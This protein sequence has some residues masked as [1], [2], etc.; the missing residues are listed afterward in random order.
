MDWLEQVIQDAM[1]KGEFDNLAGKGKPLNLERNAH[2]DP[3]KY[4]ANKMLKDGG[5]VWPWIEERNEIERDIETAQKTLARSY[6]AHRAAGSAPYARSDW[7]AATEKFRVSIV[8]I[9]KRIDVYNL[10][11]PSEPFQ[12]LRVDADKIL[13]S[14][15]PNP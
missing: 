7:D 3:E 13:Q 6:D 12:R 2:E 14:L 1:R 15:I 5:F 8:T 9:N 4:L 10:K 11:V